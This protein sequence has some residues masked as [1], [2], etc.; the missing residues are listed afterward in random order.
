LKLTENKIEVIEIDFSKPFE[1]YNTTNQKGQNITKAIIPV[2]H[3]GT[4]KIF[5]LNKKNPLYREILQKG[6]EGARLFKIL[7]TGSQASTKYVLIE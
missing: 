1:T 5:W 3:N 4:E 2:L 6:K 7:Q